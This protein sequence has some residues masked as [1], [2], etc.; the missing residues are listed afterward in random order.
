M[1]IPTG[2]NAASPTPLVF[3]FHGLTGTGSMMADITKFSPLADQENFIVIYPDGISKKWASP[4]GSI[5]DVGF[6]NALIDEISSSYNVDADR[7]FPQVHQ[8]VACS[9][10][11]WV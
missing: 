1:H 2:Y 6:I 10:I 8:M 4:G 3:V 11:G 7:I 9:L 5:D